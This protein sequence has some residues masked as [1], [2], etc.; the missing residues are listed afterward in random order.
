MICGAVVKPEISHFLTKACIKLTFL[1]CLIMSNEYKFPFRKPPDYDL[2]RLIW[3][4]PL[5]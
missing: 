3:Y 1:V 2:L 4:Y 5:S